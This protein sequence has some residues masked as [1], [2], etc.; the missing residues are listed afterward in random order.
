M[1]WPPLEC[2]LMYQQSAYCIKDRMPP[3]KKNTRWIIFLFSVWRGNSMTHTN[4]VAFQ[5]TIVWFWFRKHV[6]ICETILIKM[7]CKSLK[8]ELS[9]NNWLNRSQSLIIYF[10]NDANRSALFYSISILNRKLSETIL[11]KMVCDFLNLSKNKGTALFVVYSFECTAWSTQKQHLAAI[12][13][14]IN[15]K[16]IALFL[17][18]EFPLS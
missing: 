1:T 17:Q 14:S 13:C 4:N 12:H 15:C 16:H 9:D 7:T 10:E 3:P 6:Q 11:V 18:K 2:F 5:A 8:S